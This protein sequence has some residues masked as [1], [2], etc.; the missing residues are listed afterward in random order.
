MIDPLPSRFPRW[1]RVRLVIVRPS[2]TSE[3]HSIN[4][5]VVSLFHGL[6]SLGCFVDIQENEPV[7]DG[8]N[9]FFQRPSVIAGAGIGDARGIDR[10]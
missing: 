3:P 2:G 1:R 5:V 10:I 8:V 4:E 6:Q 9:I 7:G